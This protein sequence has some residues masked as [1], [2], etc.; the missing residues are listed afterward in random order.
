VP[1]AE[2]VYTYVSEECSP[3]RGVLWSK[4][5]TPENPTSTGLGSGC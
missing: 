5:L 1:P 3:E 2:L 4:T